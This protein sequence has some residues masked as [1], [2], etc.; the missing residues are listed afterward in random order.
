MIPIYFYLRLFAFITQDMNSLIDEINQRIKNNNKNAQN[1]YDS[2]YDQNIANIIHNI[3]FFEKPC[4]LTCTKCETD[5]KLP[6]DEWFLC[7]KCGEYNGLSLLEEEIER[8]CES[9]CFIIEEEKEIP[10]VKVDYSIISKIKIGDNPN[11]I[12]Y[13]VFF[14]WVNYEPNELSSTPHDDYIMNFYLYKNKDKR[15]DLYNN[16]ESSDLI[17]IN[18]YKN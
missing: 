16:Y 4:V 13:G 6:K 17:P 5:E 12:Y 14:C 3:N 11:N 18:H 8:S 15:D 1:D 10:F 2:D 9:F 7:K